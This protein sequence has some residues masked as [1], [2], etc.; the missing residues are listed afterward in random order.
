MAQR[1]EYR[2]RHA[3]NEWRRLEERYASQDCSRCGQRQAM[4][5]WKRRYRC[6][7]GAL[8]M[9]REEN[10]AITLRE[11]FLARRG[12]HT[13]EPVRCAAPETQQSTRVHML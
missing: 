1:L 11:R 13:G 2:C 4:P 7:N 9:D 3:G 8:A 12:P 6:G 5:R 10:S